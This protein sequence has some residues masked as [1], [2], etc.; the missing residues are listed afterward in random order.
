MQKKPFP[1][2]LSTYSLDFLEEFYINDVCSPADDL[3]FTPL[4]ARRVFLK[5]I[6]VVDSPDRFVQSVFK[7]QN[8]IAGKELES[9][10]HVFDITLNQDEISTLTTMIADEDE[11]IT[12]QQFLRF[13]QEHDGQSRQA[14]RQAKA[15]ARGKEEEE[16]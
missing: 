12:P 1:S 13:W 5:L 16:E 10:M 3:W 11:V 14:V 6:E 2:S 8:Q 9:R 15:D 4:L 7:G